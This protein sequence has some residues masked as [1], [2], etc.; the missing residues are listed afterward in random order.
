[1]HVRRTPF[2][3][4][5]ILA[6]LAMLLAITAPGVCADEATVP[7]TTS[8]A[9]GERARIPVIGSLSEGGDV[10]ITVRFDPNVCRITQAIGADGFALRCSEPEIRSVRSIDPRTTEMV[11]A[12]P[13]SISVNADT[14]VVLELE[15][16]VGVDTVGSIGVSSI[17][18]NGQEIADPTVNTGTV[19][20]RGGIVAVPSTVEGFVGN[21][22]NPFGQ[23]TRVAFVVEDPGTVRFSLCTM[24]GRLVESF[25][26]FAASA[27]ENAV[28]LE[29][30][31]W[32][33]S[34]GA[35]LIRME[36]ESGTYFHPVTV[37]K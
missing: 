4:I 11:I 29:I 30:I 21:Y 12:C 25:G 18:V 5:R 19:I 37:M 15:G 3:P 31:G 6:A 1:M 33:V 26:P 9:I 35:Y 2:T 22:P 32:Q 8:L 16:V 34:A 14:L 36:T 13:F 7:A 17:A 23:R 10:A 27:G 24:Q 28:D 20:R